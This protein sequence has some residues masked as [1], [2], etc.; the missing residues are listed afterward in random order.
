MKD[1]SSCRVGGGLPPHSCL[2]PSL[3]GTRRPTIVE[4][5][6][7]SCPANVGMVDR[8]TSSID[9]MPD[10]QDQ[11]SHQDAITEIMGRIATTVEVTGVAVHLMGKA[12]PISSA[13]REVA[14]SAS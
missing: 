1:P 14:T 7:E 9:Q 3:P 12:T 2:T 6:S 13:R 11:Q 10:E 5:L 8:M 4:T